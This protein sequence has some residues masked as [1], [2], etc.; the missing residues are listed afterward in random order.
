MFYDKDHDFHK[1]R[2]KKFDK[3]SSTDSKFDSLVDLYREFISLK[4][5]VPWEKKED[6][7]VEVLNVAFNLYEKSIEEYKKIMKVNL[8][9]IKLMSGSKNITLEN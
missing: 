8:G 6:K 7:R 4:D 9:M 5:L 1:Y 2:V 3:K